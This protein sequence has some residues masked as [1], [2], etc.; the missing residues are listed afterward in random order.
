MGQ[1][2][3]RD[4][5]VD[6]LL[7][8]LSHAYMNE[9]PNYVADK[10]FPIVPVRKQSAR[11][12]KYTKADWFRDDAALRSP[13]TESAGSGFTVNTT[14]T[15]FCDNF[16]VHKD[17]ADE[18]RE[19]TDAPY[20]VDLEATM[21]VT[22]KLMLRREI[23]W[24]TDFFTTSKW[25]TDSNQTATPWSDYGL[26]DPIGNVETAKDSIHK[27]TA[28]EANTA[29]I[30]REVW[31]KL[32]HHPDF[33]ERIKYT[34]R[35]VL[36]SDIVASILEIERL[37]IGKAIYNTYDEGQADSATGANYSYI[38]GD[39]ALILHVAPRPALLTPSAGYTFH[40]ANFGALSFIR[41]LRNDFGQFDRIE[42]HTYF[43]QKAIGQDLG[44]YL[45]NLVA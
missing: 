26:G 3:I 24:A 31:S 22:D 14:D 18:V 1:P 16:A 12:A 38:M 23:A 28:R 32:K 30:G 37:L 33:I 40:W 6:Q 4:A 5:H 39:S 36:T 35:G 7:T 8:L 17:V 41:R 2:D 27:V 10:I 45:Y 25:G 15:Y 44:Y 43:D 42:G 34:Q 11:I 19:N 13:G 29:V 21:L 9:A 20:D